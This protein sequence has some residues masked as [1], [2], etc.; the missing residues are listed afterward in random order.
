MPSSAKTRYY[1]P[2]GEPRIIFHH[3]FK[4]TL[5]WTGDVQLQ[6]SM[7]FAD[8]NSQPKPATVRCKSILN[9][10]I[11]RAHTAMPRLLLK[12]RAQAT[13]LRTCTET[14]LHQDCIPCSLSHS[15]FALQYAKLAAEAWSLKELNTD[16]EVYIIAYS[17]H[18]HVLKHCCKFY[19]GVPRCLGV[20]VIASESDGVS[21]RSQ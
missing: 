16:L 21:C 3:T 18:E 14:V 20:M 6:P 11:E 7:L 1:I 2:C 19:L 5:S 13:C 10:N 17:R 8:A 15:T 12:W 9:Y 4:D